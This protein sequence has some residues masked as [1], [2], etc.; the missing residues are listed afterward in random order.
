MAEFSN[1]P[2]WSHMSY[3]LLSFAVLLS[4]SNIMDSSTVLVLVTHY[5]YGIINEFCSFI[6]ISYSPYTTF[7]QV[8]NALLAQLTSAKRE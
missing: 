4:E 8:P 3:R 1:T 7:E 5:Y 2:R 6:C